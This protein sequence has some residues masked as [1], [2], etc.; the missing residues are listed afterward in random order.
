MPHLFD[1]YLKPGKLG[2]V[3]PLLRAIPYR[4]AADVHGLC[5]VIWHHR[6]SGNRVQV[7]TGPGWNF[8]FYQ[9]QEIRDLIAYLRLVNNPEDDISFKRVVNLPPR[10]LGD[11]AIQSVT[12]LAR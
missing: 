6:A 3:G 7:A 1:S 4:T 2:Q 12:E 11:K 9:R 8:V 5:E 10:G